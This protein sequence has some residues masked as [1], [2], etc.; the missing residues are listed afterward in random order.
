VE[1]EKTPRERAEALISLLVSDWR[2]TPRQGLWAIRVA[3][4][5]SLLFA[6]GYA[7]GVTLWDWIKLLIV[8]AV[9]AAGGFW[10][11]RQQQECQQEDNRQQQERQREDNRRQQERG[12][13]I[14]NHRAQDQALQ[15]YLD[16]MAQ[17][18]I[19]IDIDP[20]SAEFDHASRTVAQVRTLT[21]LT[22]LDGHRKRSVLQFLFEGNL[23]DK[24]DG[25]VIDLAGADLSGADLIWLELLRADLSEANLSSA[26]LVRTNL[27]DANLH[28]SR[29]AGADLFG[30][31]LRVAN[32]SRADLHGAQMIR[33]HLR[34]ANLRGADLRG[35]LLFAADLMGADLTAS[36]LTDAVVTDNQLS[37]AKL[38]QHASLQDIEGLTIMPNG[39]K[40]EDWLKDRKDRQED[41]D[42]S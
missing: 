21:V 12:L 5:L 35:A 10:F 33:A 18:L 29:L 6:V 17:L 30:A 20:L 31:D 38:A 13:E 41:R 28:R 39:Q 27:G 9:I 40:Y 19:E 23:I 1:P 37:Q 25:P 16:Q 22:R 4:L 42:P 7:Y 8:P 15:T 11:N 3:I 36:D 32:L 14:E 26:A 2:P 34:G 24:D